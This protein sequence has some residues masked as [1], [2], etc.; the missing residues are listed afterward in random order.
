MEITE[1]AKK[2]NIMNIKEE[3]QIYYYHKYNKLIDEQKQI[4]ETN[5][6]QNMFDMVKQHMNTP[7]LTSQTQVG[8]TA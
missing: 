5:N 1:R 2:G 6:L 4:K 3:F 8:Y 7:T